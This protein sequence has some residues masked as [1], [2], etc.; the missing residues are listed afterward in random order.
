MTETSRPAESFDDATR[1]ERISE[2]TFRASV[3]DGWQQGRGAF[4][5]LAIGLCLRALEAT[6]DDPTRVLRT[7]SAEI[8]SPV[9][10][11]ETLLEVT[12]LRRGSGV[13]ALEVHLRQGGEVRARASGVFGKPRGVDVA[14]APPPPELPPIPAAVPMPPRFT[15]HFEIRPTGPLP[16]SGADTATAEGWVRPR[17]PFARVSGPEIACLADTWWPAF[18]ARE[19]TFRPA[20]TVGFMLQLTPAAF[21]LPPDALCFFR[22]RQLHAAAGFSHELREL[23]SPEGELLALNAQTFAII[24]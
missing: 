12:T 4:G 14:D 5:G 9:L 15:A 13:D 21:A 10:V 16:L 6:Q 7:A 2:T 19:R 11:G 8:P 17:V 20:G 1:L 23:W 24:Q 22:S 18:L 3:P